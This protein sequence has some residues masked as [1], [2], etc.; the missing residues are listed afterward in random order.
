MGD[1]GDKVFTH[2]F[3]LV[4]TGDIAHQHQMFIVAVARDVELDMQVVVDWRGNVQWLEV[5]TCFKIFLEAWVTHQIADGLAAV[6]RGLEPQQGLCGAVPPFKVAVTVEH[7]HGVL[8]CSR[9]FLYSI[10]DRLQTP[11]CALVATLQVVDAV[12]HFPPQ[13]VAVRRRFI[14]FVLAQPVVQAQ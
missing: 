6:L 11:A 5:V 13:A 2:L 1:I 4:Q 9:R 3:K 7:H 12:K 8:E 14:R 10:D